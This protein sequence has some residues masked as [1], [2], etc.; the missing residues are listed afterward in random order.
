MDSQFLRLL[1]TDSTGTNGKENVLVDIS[2]GVPALNTSY[3]TIFYVYMI[4]CLGVIFIIKP[5]N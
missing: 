1:N 4:V 2:V 3:Y 5:G